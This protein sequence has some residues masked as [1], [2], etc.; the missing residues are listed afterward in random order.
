MHSGAAYT[1]EALIHALGTIRRLFH[2][3]EWPNHFVE[4]GHGSDEWHDAL[5]RDDQRD[6]GTREYLPHVFS[7][8]GVGDQHV[9]FIE[10]AYDRA[11]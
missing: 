8:P 3:P 2:P 7:N 5:G 9:D 1:R 10:P 6:S 11:G 4:A